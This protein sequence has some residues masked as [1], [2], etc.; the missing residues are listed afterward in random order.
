MFVR[1]AF[2]S[3]EYPEFVGSA[4]ND[5]MGV[6]VDGVNC[7]TVEGL[8]VSINTVNEN[9]NASYYVDNLQ[10]QSG[11]QTS[12]DGLTVP[13]TCA[14]DVVPGVPVEIEIAVADTSDGRYDSAVAL[15][16]RGIWSE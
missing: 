1:Y 11:Y 8:P 7:A 6:F 9:V 2:G 3:E 10:G 12:L 16:D 13:L 4:Y 5:V 14:V 15:L